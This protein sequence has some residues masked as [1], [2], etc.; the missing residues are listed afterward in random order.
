MGSGR[1]VF[2]LTSALGGR[3]GPGGTDGQDGTDG[4]TFNICFGGVMTGSICCCV[5]FC[6]SFSYPRD[7]KHPVLQVLAKIKNMKVCKVHVET[8]MVY[9]S[10]FHI[11]LG[12]L[13]HICSGP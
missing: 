9:V 11:I 5:L 12:N 10:V 2:R 1:G 8:I 3:G 6:L 4:R 7:K 13:H